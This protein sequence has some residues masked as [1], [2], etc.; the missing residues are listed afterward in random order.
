MQEKDAAAAGQKLNVAL[1]S[2]DHV[3]PPKEVGLNLLDHAINGIPF[4][5]WVPVFAD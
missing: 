3:T 2:N 5:D 4:V 1:Y